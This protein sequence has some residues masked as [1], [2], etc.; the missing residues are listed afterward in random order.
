MARDRNVLGATANVVHPAA[1]SQSLQLVHGLS[2]GH[3]RP[4]PLRRV[5]HIA[6]RSYSLPLLHTADGSN[7]PQQTCIVKTSMICYTRQGGEWPMRTLLTV[8]D[9][10]RYLN[11]SEDHVRRLIRNGQVE[12]VCVGKRAVRIREEALWDLLKVPVR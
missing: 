10:A 1:L 3:E 7:L 9:V 4:S 12:A 8:A 5:P 2:G 6:H 11:V